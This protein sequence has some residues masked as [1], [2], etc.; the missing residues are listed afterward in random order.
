MGGEEMDDMLLRKMMRKRGYTQEKLAA[1]I[2]VDRSTLNRKMNDE[3]RCFSMDEVFA[4]GRALKLTRSELSA[5]FFC[6]YSM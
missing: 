6:G 4:I 5:V 1:A 3:T 2:G